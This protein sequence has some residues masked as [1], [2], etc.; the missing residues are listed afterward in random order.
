MK[1]DEFADRFLKIY[2]PL[3]T[4][5][6]YFTGYYYLARYLGFFGVAGGY[7]N[8]PLEAI[9]LNAFVVFKIVLIC[10]I[11]ALPLFKFACA[12][13]HSNAIA[14][15]WPG[16]L[17][18]FVLYFLSRVR[19]TLSKTLPDQTTRFLVRKYRLYWLYQPIPLLKNKAL[20][21]ISVPLLLIS[22]QETAGTIGR[23]DAFELIN[24]NTFGRGSYFIAGKDAFLPG[25]PTTHPL[26]E[27]AEQPLV[28]VWDDGNILYFARLY[29]TNANY[30]KLAPGPDNPSDRTIWVPKKQMQPIEI[31]EVP[32]R[33]T[34]VLV[35]LSCELEG[36]EILKGSNNKCAEN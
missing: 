25:L 12:P 35:T 9:A 16:V 6:V 2:L 34:S 28:K 19:V 21:F 10:S 13:E 20:F 4:V 31:I 27:F 24:Q 26:A 1:T 11:D 8:F 22:L 29:D 3:L 7:A 30:T 15:F 33:L 17:C 32:R 36:R 23:A 14:Y 18:I 5:F